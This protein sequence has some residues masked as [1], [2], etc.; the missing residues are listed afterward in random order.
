MPK[1]RSRRI[2]ALWKTRVFVPFLSR[3]ERDERTGLGSDAS[4][5]GSRASEQSEL[6]RSARNEPAL[7]GEISAGHRKRGGFECL[8]LLRYPIKSSGLRFS[9]ILSTAA[10][11]SPPFIRHRRRSG[12]SPQFKPPPQ[13][14]TRRAI[15]FVQEYTLLLYQCSN[16]CFACNIN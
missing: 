8:F 4:A 14:P 16:L 10:T 3:Q 9:S 6:L 12:R 11:H 15:S 1:A 13:D 5:A 7:T 2:Y